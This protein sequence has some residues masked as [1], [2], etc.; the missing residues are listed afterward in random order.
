MPWVAAADVLKWYL[1]GK[2]KVPLAKVSSGLLT[3]A[4]A[5]LALTF[6]STI[7]GDL[8]I[9]ICGGTLPT[10]TGGHGSGW[11]YSD[12]TG[13]GTSIRIAWKFA[14][15][16]DVGAT[17]TIS[18]V[19]NGAP[20]AWVS[21]RG[22]TTMVLKESVALDSTT[23]L[24]FSGFAPASSNVGA[25]IIGF[26]HGGG[27][28]TSMVP[29]NGWVKDVENPNFGAKAS[30]SMDGYAGGAVTVTGLT[31]AICGTLWELA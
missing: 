2:S 5:P 17:F 28:T 13:G 25:L 20:F 7:V 10:I 22:P 30:L 6:T 4:A 24:P 12:Q 27:T 3:S 16:A 8:L 31:G 19:A 1:W 29:P 15:A 21:Y 11:S 23:T 9:L 26:S 14:A 18:T